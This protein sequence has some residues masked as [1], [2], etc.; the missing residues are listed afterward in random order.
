MARV[1]WQ[2][3]NTRKERT[4]LTSRNNTTT[5]ERPPNHRI[6]YGAIKGLF[7]YCMTVW[8]HTSGDTLCDPICALKWYIEICSLYRYSTAT[9]SCR[10]QQLS[11]LKVFLASL[12]DVKHQLV[13]NTWKAEIWTSKC[14]CLQPTSISLLLSSWL[15]NMLQNT[16]LKLLWK[17]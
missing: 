8:S 2:N 3:E 17:D 9:T 16:L 1:G 4:N 14:R 7:K 13:C 6:S 12:I 11:E 15:S 5:R 10:N